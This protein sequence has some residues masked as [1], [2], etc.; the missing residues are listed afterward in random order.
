MTYRRECE[1]YQAEDVNF[2]VK[3]LQKSLP[4]EKPCN[5]P[6]TVLPETLVHS[7]SHTGIR[8]YE[9]SVFF[10]YEPN[11]ILVGKR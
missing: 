4:R 10:G 7:A 1:G 11:V 6:Y 9:T 3:E 2:R 8:S 5:H